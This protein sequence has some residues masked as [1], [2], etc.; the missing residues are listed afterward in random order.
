MQT[1]NIHHCEQN[2]DGIL[3]CGNAAMRGGFNDFNWARVRLAVCYDVSVIKGHLAI[4]GTGD[5]CGLNFGGMLN[6]NI[7]L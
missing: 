2:Q 4:A 6:S 1:V 7:K 5:V 3:E